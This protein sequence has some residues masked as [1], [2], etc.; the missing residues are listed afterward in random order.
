M[1]L[2]GSKLIHNMEKKTNKFWLLLFHSSQFYKKNCIEN[3]KCFFCSSFQLLKQ[4]LMHIAVVWL[5]R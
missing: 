1:L 5:E 4:L 2:I 3:R